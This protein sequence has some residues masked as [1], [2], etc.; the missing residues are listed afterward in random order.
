[1]HREII[2]HLVTW[3]DQ[4]DR[5]PL[6]MRGARQVGK[7]TVVEQFGQQYFSDVFKINFELQRDY[8]PC[9]E[10]LEP[11]D[12]L[13]KLYALSGKTIHPGKTLLFLDEIQDCPNAIMALRYFYEKRPDLH[14]IAAGSL[15]EFTLGDENF[16]MPVGRVQSCY[17]KP[18]SFVEYLMAAD[19]KSLVEYMQT[20]T[21]QSGIDDVIHQALLQH[22]RQYLVVGG[23]PAVL[24]NYFATHDMEQS[25]IRQSVILDTYQRDFRKYGKEHQVKYLQS[26]FEKAPGMV[27]KHFQYKMV[28]AHMHSRDLKRAID[29][30]CK[31]G[32]IYTVKSTAASGLPLISTVNDR[33]FK[34]LV[35]DVGLMNNSTRLSAQILMDENLILLHQGAVAEQFVGQELLAYAP[36]Y[37]EEELYYWQRDKLGAVS[38]VDY[39]TAMESGIYPIE[40]KSGS[41]GRLK[42]LQIYIDEKN[43]NFG[44]RISQNTLSFGKRILSVPLYMISQLQRLIKEAGSLND[45]S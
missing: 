36:Y 5:L 15:L 26:I 39:V 12:I 44:I 33:K 18:M 4:T 19:M 45:S 34:L 31:A 40:V 24:K 43:I 27:A 23:M 11:L 25:Q 17:L 16:R 29:L 32:V 7:T 41:T 6:L 8:L 13:K 20:V 14:I 2:K 35:L 30:L 3:K 37:R 9:F 28:D 1:M 38:E 42:S 21:L 22:L 10:T